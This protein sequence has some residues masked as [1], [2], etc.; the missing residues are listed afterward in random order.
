MDKRNPLKAKKQKESKAPHSERNKQQASQQH[1]AGSM[2]AGQHGVTS[3]FGSYAGQH[4]AQSQSGLH[5]GQHG[6][7]GQHTGYGE[8]RQGQQ[9]AWGAASSKKGQFDQSKF[10]TR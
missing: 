10:R 6:I 3:Q 5:A 4:G 7:Q 1:S 9:A 2:H 8:Y